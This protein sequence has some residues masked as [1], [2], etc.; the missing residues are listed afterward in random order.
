M[1]KIHFQKKFSKKRFFKRYLLQ[2]NEF[3]SKK[4]DRYFLRE[5]VEKAS[6][7]LP[8]Q[9]I[10]ENFVHH[11]PLAVFEDLQFDQAIQ[12]MEEVFSHPSPGKNMYELLKVDP[13]ERVKEAL[14]DLCS[15]FLDRFFIKLEIKKKFKVFFKGS[16]KMAI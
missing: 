11:N 4:D 12:K 13:R 9:A 5:V 16:S 15:A 2:K 8:H 1:K 3:C 6:E 7:M 14:T 10:L